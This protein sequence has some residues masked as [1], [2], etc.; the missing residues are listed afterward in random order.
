MISAQKMTGGLLDV[1]NLRIIFI[2]FSCLFFLQLAQVGLARGSQ[3]I[4]QNTAIE[5]ID[6]SSTGLTKCSDATLVV[7]SIYLNQCHDPDKDTETDYGIRLVFVDNGKNNP[8]ILFE[9]KGVQI[10]I[11]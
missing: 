4:L 6:L 10:V 5:K 9:S 3:Y 11:I 7:A 8:T 1:I 2:M